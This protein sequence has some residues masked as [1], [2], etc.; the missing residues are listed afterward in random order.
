MKNILAFAI[1]L[2][3]TCTAVAQTFPLNN[4]PVGKGPGKQGWTPLAPVDGQCFSSVGGVPTFLPCPTNV[5]NAQTSNYILGTTDCGKTIS[6]GGTAFYTLTV[7]AAST[8]PSTCSVDVVNID[9]GRGKKMAIN[10]TTFPNNN[11]LWPK[12]SFTLANA[13]NTWQIINPP[14]RWKLFVGAQFEVDSTGNNANDCL[15][16]GATGACA[17]IQGAIDLIVQ[18]LDANAQFVKIHTDCSS[19]PKTYTESVRLKPIVGQNTGNDP[20]SNLNPILSGDATTPTN[21]II[22][23]SSGPTIQAVGSTQFNIEGFQLKNTDGS[24]PCVLSDQGSF[25]RAGKMD[26]NSCNGASGNHIVTQYESGY[27][28]TV[29]YTISAGASSHAFSANDGTF[30]EAFNINCG[31]GAFAFPGGF[32]YSDRNSFQQWVGT[33]FTTCASVTGPRYTAKTGG[34]IDTNGGGASFFPGNSVGTATAP[35]WYN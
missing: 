16:T 18:I 22:T 5:L 33:T 2:G 32:A 6:L 30:L 4:I 24:S 8:Y 10:A 7:N 21:C 3:L 25:I 27:K 23:S 14:G 11:I 19:P 17:T 1:L 34:G 13:A 26:F 20:S 9:S 35:G 12:Q 15:G 28:A 31:G 29:G